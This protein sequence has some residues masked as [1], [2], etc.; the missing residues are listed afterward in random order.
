MDVARSREL[1]AQY[2][3]VLSACIRGLLANA[4]VCNRPVCERVVFVLRI[5]YGL[6]SEKLK[7]RT[8]SASIEHVGAETD[9]RSEKCAARSSDIVR[10]SRA[11]Q[12]QASRHNA[13]AT[14]AVI[15]NLLGSALS[16]TS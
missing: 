4:E 12:T 6:T 14:C 16:V 10:A 9:R 1:N 5:F 11:K 3:D 7:N 15:T 13:A 8:L 2:S